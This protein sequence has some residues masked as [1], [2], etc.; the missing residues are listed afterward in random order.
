MPL[1]WRT[2]SGGQRCH[3]IKAE[4]E[5]IRGSMVCKDAVAMQLRVSM[6]RNPTSSSLGV[7]IA[8]GRNATFFSNLL[9][10]QAFPVWYVAP[11]FISSVQKLW[12]HPWLIFLPDPLKRNQSSVLWVVFPNVS[13]IHLFLYL[14][15]YHIVQATYLSLW[16]TARNS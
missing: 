1:F 2:V 16:N 8:K 14:F 11:L 4:A 3:N 6:N 5:V 15:C 12:S 7:L 13:Q 10:L 9:Y